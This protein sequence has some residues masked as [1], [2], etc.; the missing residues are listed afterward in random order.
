MGSFETASNTSIS[1]SSWKSSTDRFSTSTSFS[2]PSSKMTSSSSKL[3]MLWASFSTGFST[4]LPKRISLSES[5]VNASISSFRDPSSSSSWE[6]SGSHSL[7]TSFTISASETI[8]GSNSISFE[9]KTTST[10]DILSRTAGTGCSTG[11]GRTITSSWTESGSW[12]G[13][14]GGSGNSNSGRNLS[15]RLPTGISL[16][17][18]KMIDSESEDED[19]TA[20]LNRMCF[21]CTF[22]FRTGR[23]ST[24]VSVWPNASVDKPSAFINMFLWT[25][26]VVFPSIGL[27]VNTGNFWSLSTTSY[28]FCSHQDLIFP[29][30][31]LGVKFLTNTRSPTQISTV[32]IF[33]SYRL[34]FAAPAF[35]TCWFAIWIACF[36]EAFHSRTNLSYVFRVVFFVSRGIMQSIG[37]LL[38]RLN[39]SS[40]GLNPVVLLTVELYANINLGRWFFQF[41]FSFSGNAFNIFNNVRFNRSADPLPIGW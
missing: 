4:G 41:F 29:V 37:S 8:S 17:G 13:K 7:T 28:N 10:S 33:P 3:S 39:I 35:W 40:K 1:G 27:I 5:S 34:L 12:G 22:F 36:M 16:S 21:F 14:T 19:S 9:S 30:P 26:F 24:S 25:I 6:T 2:P 31:P 15:N 18:T 11:S 38:F 20:G 23:F 32:L